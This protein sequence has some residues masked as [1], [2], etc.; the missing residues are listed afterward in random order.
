MLKIIRSSFLRRNLKVN[1]FSGSSANLKIEINGKSEKI[2][3]SALWLRFFIFFELSFLKHIC[4]VQIV[5]SDWFWNGHSES[6]KFWN[7]KILKHVRSALLGWTL[8]DLDFRFPP[9]IQIQNPKPKIG[10]T[11]NSIWSPK[12]D[13]KSSFQ[14]NRLGREKSI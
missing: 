1:A 7:Q 8:I 3:F 4:W 5:V 13:F 14:K 11:L 10:P 9:E 12:L 6:Q 2:D